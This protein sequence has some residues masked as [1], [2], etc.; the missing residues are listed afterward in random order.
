[1]KLKSYLLPAV[2]IFTVQNE[3]TSISV[4][5]YELIIAYNGAS[6]AS[7]LQTP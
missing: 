1:M 7:G 4:A 6:L 2:Y 5:V 3:I